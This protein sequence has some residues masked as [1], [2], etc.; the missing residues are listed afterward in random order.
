MFCIYFNLLLNHTI[1]FSLILQINPLNNDDEC[2]KMLLWTKN[3]EGSTFIKNDKSFKSEIEKFFQ[4]TYFKFN[5]KQ[6][7]ANK[8][9][10]ICL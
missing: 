7:E 10:P 3:E 5:V 8:G 1:S 6:I 9:I 4:M 2:I